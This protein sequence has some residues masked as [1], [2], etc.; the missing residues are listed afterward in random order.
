MTDLSY[1]YGR[2]QLGNRLRNTLLPAAS[3]YVTGI[4]NSIYLLEFLPAAKIVTLE[5]L[6]VGTERNKKV[7]DCLQRHLGELTC[8]QE[9]CGE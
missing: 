7:L 9:F 5:N 6:T 3:P 4:R 8:M 1:F 2:K